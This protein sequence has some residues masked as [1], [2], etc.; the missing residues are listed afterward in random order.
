VPVAAVHPLAAAHAIAMCGLAGGGITEVVVTGD[1]PD[2]VEV[3]R[4]RWIPDGVLAWG[5]PTDSPLWEGRDP[6]LAYVCHNYA[7]KVP[8]SD[9]E[10]L[11]AQLIGSDR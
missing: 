9:P 8:A 4:R 7:C 5:E 11:S 10:S 1:R 6:D 2:L 3:A